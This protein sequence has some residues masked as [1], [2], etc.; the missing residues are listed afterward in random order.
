MN[1][2]RSGLIPQQWELLYS[3]PLHSAEDVAEFRMEGQGAVTFPKGWMRLESTRSAAEGQK[4]NLVFW[5]PEE[6]PADV[7]I[8]WRFRPIREPGL[9]IMFFSSKGADGQDLF[10]PAL[11]R[12][13]GEY[14]QYH[15]GRINAFHISYFR[16]MWAEE[17]QFHTCNLRKSY[18]FHMVAQGADPLPGVLDAADFYHLLVLKKGSSI[19]FAINDLQVL[20]WKDDGAAYGPLL[21]G[22]KLG[23]RQMAP[24]IAE[25]AEL[26]VYGVPAKKGGSK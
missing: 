13:T 19:T 5:C 21:G 22:G 25:Y 9:A 26:S 1:N 6:L 23:F 14:E 11:P 3:N 18:G 17:R 8:S 15:H 7:A 12:R 16:R 4:A 10:D 20:S 24:L 2:S